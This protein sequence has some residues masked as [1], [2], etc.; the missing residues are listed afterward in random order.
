VS[1]DERKL[2]YWKFAITLVICKEKY[3]KARRKKKKTQNRL[4][5]SKRYL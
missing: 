5:S 2:E 3:F 4:D 1:L